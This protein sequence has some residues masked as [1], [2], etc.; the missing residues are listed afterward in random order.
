VKPRSSPTPCVALNGVA[1]TIQVKRAY[2]RGSVGF[3]RNVYDS[4]A[5][6]TITTHAPSAMRVSLPSYSPF[7]T[8]IDIKFGGQDPKHVLFGAVGGSSGYHLASGHL[9]YTYL[10][11][12]GHTDAGSPPSSTAGTSMQ[13]VGYNAPSESQ[14]WTLDCTTL[15]LTAMWTNTDNTQPATTTIFYDPAVDYL[16]LTGDLAVF[17]SVF[18]EHAFPVTFTYIPVP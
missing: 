1:G 11:G 18:S 5:S 9:G 15:Q 3:V 16:G 10:S 7:N 17:Q 6:F 14:I 13:A 4:Q 12:T 8:P 2:D